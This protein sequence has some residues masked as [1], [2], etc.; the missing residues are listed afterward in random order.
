VAIVVAVS[1]RT[2]VIAIVAAAAATAAVAT[3]GATVLASSGDTKAPDRPTGPR[4]GAPPLIL[5]LGVRDDAEARELRRAA[6]LVAHGKRAEAARAFARSS[7]LEA[8]VGAAI[9]AWPE[10]TVE[11]LEQLARTHPRSALVQLHLGLARFWARQDA[12]AVTAWRA[13]ERVEPDSASAVRAGDVLHPN[14]ARGLPVFVP[15]FEPPPS[16]AKLAPA[17]QLATLKAGAQRDVEGRLLYG[18]ALQRLGRPVSA[19]REFDAALAAA[20]RNPEA[21]VA[22]AVVRFDKDDPSRAFSRLGP[23]A[24]RFPRAPTVRFH[25]G[26]MLLWMGRVDEAR[27]QLERARAVGPK[28]PIGREAARFLSRLGGIGG[29]TE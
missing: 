22:A 24:R 12:A 29:R 17:A 20:P 18:V 6:G 21:N 26:L 28:T 13:A 5:D 25:L 7:S 4:E 10:G 2:R 9:A 23:L 27:R 11:R 3:V 16:L 14:M 15:A 8:E 19:R 1:P